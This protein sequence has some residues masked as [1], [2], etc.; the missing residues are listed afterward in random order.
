VIGIL[1]SAYAAISSGNEYQY[2]SASEQCM[3]EEEP[4]EEALKR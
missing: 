3:F 1:P 4:E 2:Q